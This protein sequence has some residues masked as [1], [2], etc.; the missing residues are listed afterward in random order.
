MPP[1]GET[2]GQTKRIQREG[3]NNYGKRMDTLIV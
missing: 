3:F 1:A 2:W